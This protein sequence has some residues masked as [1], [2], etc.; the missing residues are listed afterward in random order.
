MSRAHPEAR[1]EEPVPS[2]DAARQVLETSCGRVRL[3]EPSGTDGDVYW[4][5]EW[6]DEDGAR[7]QTTGGRT[8]KSAQAKAAK[9]LQRLDDAVKA[10][11]RER[12]GTAVDAY[13]A[14]C[15]QEHSSNH[16]YRVDLDLKRKALEPL[17]G[18]RCESF[19]KRHAQAVLDACSTKTVA[20][21]LRG[22]LGA[23]LA[24]GH[25]RGYFSAGQVQMLANYRYAP[26][27]RPVA[28]PARRPAARVQGET[29][30]YVTDDEVPL[31]AAVA[32]LGDALQEWL[33]Y[34]K[35]QVE[36]IAASGTRCGE[37]LALTD[38]V[39]RLAQREL[40]ID[41]Q[42]L[43]RKDGRTG[44][45]LA[46]PKGGKTRTTVFAEVTPTGFPLAEELERRVWEVEEEHAAGANPH[47]LLFPAPQGGH[48]WPG[49]YT[50]DYFTPAALAAGW[51]QLTWTERKSEAG[52][53]VVVERHQLRHTQHSLRHR[54]AKDHIDLYGLNPAELMYIGGWESMQV[55]YERYYG[56]SRGILDAVRAKT[57]AA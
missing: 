7:H 23:F 28:K 20:K 39:V 41:W 46:R 4:R 11:G 52:R 16:A 2:S 35:L 44:E 56:L 1:A 29:E 8:V 30:R 51:E 18:T 48:H 45:R 43:P 9:V 14:F 13:V 15:E 49:N 42:V 47:R 38:G 6:Y 17:R 55:V 53:L 37:H 22:M 32:A 36:L 5:V 33:R 34:G 54:F 31:H 57:R 50:N 21:N 27:T 40:G 19:T 12:L 10:E 25:E 24:W 3:T 26:S